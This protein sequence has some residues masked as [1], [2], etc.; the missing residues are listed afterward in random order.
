[1]DQD[2]DSLDLQA[3]S[4]LVNSLDFQ[5]S[6]ALLASGSLDKTVIVQK[7][8]NSTSTQTPVHTLTGHKDV[9]VEVKF[10]PSDPHILATCDESGEVRLWDVHHG[11]CRHI[12][13][14][15]PRDVWKNQISFSADGKLLACPD[16]EVKIFRAASGQ[17]SVINIIMK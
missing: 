17:V 1:M 8:N 6:S 7:V 5:P 11:N 16:N 4:G 10:S 12:L 14:C 3:H 15:G 9:V 13:L 2:G